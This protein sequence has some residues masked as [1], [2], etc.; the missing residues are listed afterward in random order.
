MI[1]TDQLVSSMNV[2]TYFYDLPTT[3]ERRN[4]FIFPGADGETN[5]L[6][7]VNLVDAVEGLDQRVTKGLFVEGGESTLFLVSF[8]V[9]DEC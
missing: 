9:R 7:I 8:C 2:N 1:Y 5:P 6:R 3:H 4:P